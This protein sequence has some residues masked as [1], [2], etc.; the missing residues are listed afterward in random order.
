VSTPTRHLRRS[1]VYRQ[2][3]KL[4]AEFEAVADAAVALR[5]SSNS[6]E[7]ELQAARYLGIADLSPLARTGFKGRDTLA[8]LQAQGLSAPEAPNRARRQPDGSL[9]ARLSNDEFLC[10]SD[11]GAN[12][13]TVM[14][15]HD[16]WQFDNNIRCYPVPRA[17]SHCWLA[18]SGADAAEMLA[19]LCAI[20]LRRHQFADGR[21][22]QTSVARINA[23]VI[24]H[25]L[26]ATLGFYLL[27]DSASADYLWSCVGDAIREYDGALVGLGVLRYLDSEPGA[28]EF[29]P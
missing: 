18:V 6:E 12:G 19:K 10:L 5:F 9:L 16:A 15:L 2:L 24:R 22:A 7:Q 21:I 4:G 17:D 23:I 13:D 14:R 29:D 1:L 27:A 20:D 25:D 26:G 11:L 28:G 3:E 8:W